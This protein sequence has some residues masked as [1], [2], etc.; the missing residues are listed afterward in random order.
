MQ[1][2]AGTTTGFALHQ[3]RQGCFLSLSMGWLM[4][5]A[6]QTC[7]QEAA[8]LPSLVPAPPHGLTS[9]PHTAAQLGLPQ[10]LS[11]SSFAS[12]PWEH[13][14][15]CCRFPA[16]CRT[17]ENRGKKCVSSRSPE[18]MDVHCSELQRMCLLESQSKN[19]EWCQRI[20]HFTHS[21]ELPTF[22]QQS[23]KL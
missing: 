9:V 12:K 5:P 22:S 3:T 2:P 18:R 23:G 6:R 10:L 11:P 16:S 7:W 20:Q 19:P 8:A 14:H 13:S 17:E 15:S 4:S 1:T 21:P